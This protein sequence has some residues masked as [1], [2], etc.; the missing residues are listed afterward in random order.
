MTW[1]MPAAVVVPAGLAV[2]GVLTARVVVAARALNREVARINQQ[3]R[4]KADSR[5]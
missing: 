2:L 1:I 4:V 3:F 5:G